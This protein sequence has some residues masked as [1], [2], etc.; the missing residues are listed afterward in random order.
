MPALKQQINFYQDIFQKPEVRFPV[1]QMVSVWLLVLVV[2]MLLTGVDFYRTQM[3]RKQVAQLDTTQARLKKAV[4]TMTDQLGKRVVDS[5][6]EKQENELRQ[7]LLAKQQ[8]LAMLRAQ[9]DTH[10]TR[11][12]DLLDG[13]ASLDPPDL[14]LTRI[15][16]SAPGPQ[17]SL[18]G[19]TAQAK[20]LPDYLAALSSEPVFTGLRFRMLN[21]E[22]GA[23]QSRYL[24]FSV[25]TERDEST[26]R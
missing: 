19:L 25:S 7:G 23:D 1:Q 16:V 22:R 8:F 9:S 11:F 2:L 5:A 17:L 21:L 3:L 26:A 10:D 13:L 4:D 15:G 24:T 12:S 14:W 6:L 20:A 18:T